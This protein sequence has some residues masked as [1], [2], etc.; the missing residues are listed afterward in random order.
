MSDKDT[1]LLSGLESGSSDHEQLG[2]S[3]ESG[4]EVGG[5]VCGLQVPEPCKSHVD[6]MNVPMT[7]QGYAERSMRPGA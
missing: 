6:C 2:Q 4:E 5:G 7:A 3:P 1:G